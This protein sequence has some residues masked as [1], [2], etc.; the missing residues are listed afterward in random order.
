[1]RDN[2]RITTAPISEPVTLIEAKNF[3]RVDGTSDDSYITDL[4]ETSRVM[5]E[6]IL[7]RTMFTTTLT[8]TKKDLPLSY[9]YNAEAEYYDIA[10]N[11]IYLPHGLV[12]S[13]TSVKYT[14]NSGTVTTVTPSDYTLI[15][16]EKI[17]LLDGNLWNNDINTAFVEIEYVAGETLVASIPKPL[18]NA[19]LTL[20]SNMYNSRSCDC[21][22]PKTMV[23]SIKSYALPFYTRRRSISIQRG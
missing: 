10:P 5:L 14:D 8:L 6:N 2:P 23:R 15:N 13:V 21:D 4:I 7:H 9:D 1:M 18:K 22:I 17:S 3:L 20:V 11:E 19:V 16:S 12:K